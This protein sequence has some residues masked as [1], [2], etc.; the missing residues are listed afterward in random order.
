MPHPYNVETLLTAE[1][2]VIDIQNVLYTSAEP[3]ALRVKKHLRDI[4]LLLNKGI[5]EYEKDVTDPIDRPRSH[6]RCGISETQQKDM[7]NMIREALPRYNK[8]TQSRLSKLCTIAERDNHFTLK[9]LQELDR[10]LAILDQIKRLKISAVN[11]LIGSDVFKV[12]FKRH[13][14]GL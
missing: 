14:K 12:R 7:I 8:L 1:K 11:T 13:L 9:S 4:R 5:K 10:I 2:L 6:F 3:T